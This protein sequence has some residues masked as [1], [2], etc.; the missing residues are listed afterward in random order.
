MTGEARVTVN[1][2]AQK[3]CIQISAGD[4]AYTSEPLAQGEQLLG[5][6]QLFEQEQQKSGRIARLELL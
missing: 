6:V 5:A 2:C 4:L 3:E 1:I